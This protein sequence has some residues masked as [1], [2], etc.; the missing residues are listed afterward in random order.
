LWLIPA[1][2]LR[3]ELRL[4]IH[5]AAAAPDAVEFGPHVTSLFVLRWRGLRDEPLA[6]SCP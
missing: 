1:D 2:P 5:E 3:S 6:E 4:M